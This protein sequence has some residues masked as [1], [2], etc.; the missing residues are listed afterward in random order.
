MI[1]LRAQTM[2]YLHRE[3][4]NYSH[5]RKRGLAFE[6]VHPFK[7][8]TYLSTLIQIGNYLPNPQT[9]PRSLEV[10]FG[11]GYLISLFA[12]LGFRAV[13]IERDDTA[14]QYSRAILEEK[15]VSALIAKGDGFN[16][17]FKDNTFD[18]VSSFGMIE[19][20]DLY[21]QGKLL[22]EMSRVSKNLVLVG[23]PNDNPKSNYQQFKS[24]KTYIPE[25]EIIPDLH[26]SCLEAGLDPIMSSGC[27]AI[28]G[29]DLKGILV[30]GTLNGDL[31][32]R[33]EVSTPRDTLARKGFLKFTLAK[34]N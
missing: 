25:V 20:Y 2:E 22:K 21:Q 4:E 3:F 12:R 17:P 13:G 14:F 1:N 30:N 19:H 33:T 6:S 31:L 7:S 24:E 23:V 27:N 34:K 11:S 16:L 5:Q 9:E 32:L 8:H 28:L 18:I 26:R 29:L 10:G 15:M